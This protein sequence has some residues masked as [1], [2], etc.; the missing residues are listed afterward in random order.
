MSIDAKAQTKERIL[1][2]TEKLLY[3][4]GVRSTSVAKLMESAGLTVGGFYAHFE[5]KN[6]LVLES[7]H[8]M[9]VKIGNKVSKLEG[10]TSEKQIKFIK[11]YLSKTHRDEP[12]TGCPL[13]SLAFEAA[14]MNQEFRHQFSHE[15]TLAFEKRLQLLSPQATQEDRARIMMEF[16]AL[17]GAQILARATKGTEISD[18][19]LA[20]CERA[21]LKDKEPQ[22]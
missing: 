1:A 12:Q 13:P 21:L 11:T 2:A 22:S 18:T 19:I 10:S 6:A 4:G 8:R 16:C 5:N 9:L 17:V 3:Q 14:Q 15:L 20:S 7:F